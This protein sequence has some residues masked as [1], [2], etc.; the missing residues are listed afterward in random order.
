MPFYWPGKVLTKENKSIAALLTTA[1]G[2]QAFTGGIAK[3]PPY[4]GMVEVEVN[5]I[6]AELGDGVKTKDCF[7]SGDG[8]TT[9]RQIKDI[10]AA[11][12]LHWNGSVAGF[13]LATT[14]KIELTYDI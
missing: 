9:A 3:T 13:E 1:D 12:T 5:G 14:D 4:D 7:F 2:D 11:D 8:G 6:Q 10:T